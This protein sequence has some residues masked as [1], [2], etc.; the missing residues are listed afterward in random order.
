MIV[1]QLGHHEMAGM[2]AVDRF[3]L[4][5]VAFWAAPDLF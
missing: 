4:K 5:R 2:G 3:S 1:E